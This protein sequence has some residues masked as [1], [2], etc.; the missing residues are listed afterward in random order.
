MAAAWT[1]EGREGD[2][3]CSCPQFKGLIFIYGAIE[4]ASFV[5]TPPT[6]N[7]RDRRNLWSCKVMKISESFVLKLLSILTFIIPRGEAL[8]LL[9]S[10]GSRRKCS[11]RFNLVQ[12]FS[13]IRG[14][15]RLSY[16]FLHFI[17]L[18]LRNFNFSIPCHAFQKKLYSNHGKIRRSIGYSQRS[19][20]R[21]EKEAE[22]SL[23][24]ACL[25]SK[26]PVDS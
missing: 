19:F 10:D 8:S 23:T 9:L 17:L 3:R 14:S 21:R 24:R 2:F 1:S 7:L 18:H 11:L 15:N 25:D 13:S 16:P 12:S 26:T 5:A 4:T 6:K 20:F 22:T